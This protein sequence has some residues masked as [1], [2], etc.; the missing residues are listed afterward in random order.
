MPE[1]KQKIFELAGGLSYRAFELPIE[2]KII[3]NV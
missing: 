2:G 1:G 3:V